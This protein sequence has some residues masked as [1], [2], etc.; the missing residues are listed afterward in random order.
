MK[1]ED[2]AGIAIPVFFI[3]LLFIESRRTAR[4]FEPVKN[5]RRTGALFFAMVLVVG[6]IV[7]WLLP[8][9]WLRQ[10]SVFD[11][12]H[13]GLWGVPV[14]VLVTTFFGYWLHRAMHR[15]T[16]LWLGMHQLHHGAK[17]VDLA[18]AYF[19]HPLE[20]VAK[21]GLATLVTAWLLG[22]PP[23][24]AALVSVFTATT[25]MF[26]H[27][28]ITTPRWLGYIVQRP[29]SHCLHHEYRIHARNYSDLPL[30]DLVFG[31]FH[32]P[33]L[34]DGKVGYQLQS[35]PRVADMLLMRDVNARAVKDSKAYRPPATS[36]NEPV[37]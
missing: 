9:V 8:V 5:W 27:T 19:A 15:F 6:S 25:S 7:P 31:S 17:R 14:G 12:D 16:S 3:L 18:G 11:W 22:L 32:N 37:V 28:N 34:F 29:E 13:L 36:T 30:W 23:L 26:Q 10:H 4:R 1:P 24:V 35:G 21:V 2:L 33:H 20:I